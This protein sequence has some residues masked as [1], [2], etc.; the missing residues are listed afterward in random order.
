MRSEQLITK[1]SFQVGNAITRWQ[2]LSD[3]V[4]FAFAMRETLNTINS[5]SFNNFMLRIGETKYEFE[6]CFKQKIIISLLFV[7]VLI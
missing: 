3:L 2:H 1:L 5:Q 4:E 7:Q 6:M